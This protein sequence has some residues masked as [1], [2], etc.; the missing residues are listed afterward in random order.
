MLPG[1]KPL[2]TSFARNP[3]DIFEGLPCFDSKGGGLSYD[4]SFNNFQELF[5]DS[6]NVEA[7]LSD[8]PLLSR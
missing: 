5:I 3:I 2:F 7:W 4:L 8:E 1:Y 6:W